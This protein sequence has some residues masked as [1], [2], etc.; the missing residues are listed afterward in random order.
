MTAQISELDAR[1]T[2]RIEKL[3]L[4]LATRI[5]QN[6]ARLDQTNV[7]IDELQRDMASYFEKVIL[8][9]DTAFSETVRQ[10]EFGRLENQVRELASRVAEPQGKWEKGQKEQ[11]KTSRGS[12]DKARS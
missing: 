2:G 8:K 4:R 9:L 7:R 11:K 5:E 6:S 10:E 3:D 1:L 12:G